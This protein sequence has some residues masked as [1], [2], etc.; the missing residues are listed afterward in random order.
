MKSS[1]SHNGV[2]MLADKLQN[3]WPAFRE[4][5]KEDLVYILK[6]IL[7]TMMSPYKGPITW[8]PEERQI[9]MRFIKIYRKH[10]NDYQTTDMTMLSDIYSNIQNVALKTI[11]NI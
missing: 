10:R 7:D 9:F 2:C 8:T 3:E 1:F 6:V 4:V 11:L 5:S